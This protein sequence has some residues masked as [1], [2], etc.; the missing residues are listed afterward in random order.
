MGEA[1]TDLL[2]AAPSESQTLI[3]AFASEHH[4]IPSTFCEL[5][6]AATGKVR[7]TRLPCL[8]C[9]NG[10]HTQQEN[11]LGDSSLVAEPPS[12]SPMS[13]HYVRYEFISMAFSNFL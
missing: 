6:T 1:S 4:K 3:D 8:R 7:C 11:P 9:S 10:P 12:P 2:A 13:I 5:H